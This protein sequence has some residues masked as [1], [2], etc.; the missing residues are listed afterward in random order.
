MSEAHSPLGDRQWTTQGPFRKV[1]LVA[2][3][4]CFGTAPDRAGTS[5]VIR[6]E[7]GYAIGMRP[8]S[9]PL[10][11]GLCG[12]LTMTPET[13]PAVVHHYCGIDTMGSL[14]FC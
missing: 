10:R 12:D 9:N 7:I 14:E 1:L 6:L 4:A 8:F 3:T 2:V 13:D 11:K 5:S